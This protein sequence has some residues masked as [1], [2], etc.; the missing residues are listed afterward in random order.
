MPC[1]TPHSAAPLF[2]L[3]PGALARLMA[4]FARQIQTGL[5]RDGERVAALPA[6][7]PRPAA[8]LEGVAVV[9]DLGGTHARAALVALCTEGGLHLLAGPVTAPV[10]GVNDPS[11][12]REAFF[13]AQAA[14]VAALD[15]PAGLPI[16]YCFSFPAAVQPDGDARLVR[17]TKDLRVSGV[18]GERVGALLV[19]ALRR[20][21]L[22]PG[23][24]RVLN[25][26][27]AA[28]LAGARRAGAEHA[29]VIGL[30]VGTGTNMASFFPRAR[31]PKLPGEG[32]DIAVN[33]ESGN[34]EPCELT[35]WDL[36]LDDSCDNPGRQGFEKAVSGRYL[37]RLA[38][39]AL[40][41]PSLC[42]LAE[43]AGALV[44][45]RAGEGEAAEVARAILDRSADL[46]A[47]GL[48]ALIEALGPG[49][50]LVAAEGGL[51]WKAGGY[52][53][54]V[55]VTLGTLL[56]DSGRVDIARIDDANLEGAAVA[57]L[58]AGGAA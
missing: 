40:G 50:I 41:D 57:A 6:W 43:G 12:T 56:G 48:A 16:G 3:G 17:W 51:F 5:A 49:R 53:A 7:L 22:V 2:T 8:G 23:P 14:L 34:L 25:D 33:L 10:P 15:P 52:A 11:V 9:V 44:R 55:A 31:L 39:L 36:E 29:H 18:E 19:A 46:V 26:T 37:P 47:C 20:R 27:V 28:L 21:G 58:S 32:P 13:D 30:V 42:D 4:N 45:L 54:R 35:Q 1:S 24:V 38:A